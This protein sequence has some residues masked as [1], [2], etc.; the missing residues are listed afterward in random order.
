MMANSPY[1]C[2]RYSLIRKPEHTI[3][4]NANSNRGEQVLG[5]L[6]SHAVQFVHG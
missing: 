5:N 4:D 1:F 6:L 3:Q 2:N